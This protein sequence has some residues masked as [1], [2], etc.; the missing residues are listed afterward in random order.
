MSFVW[1]ESAVVR[2]LAS[3]SLV[4]ALLAS[5]ALADDEGPLVGDP[6]NGARLYQKATGD[7]SAKVDGAWLNRYGD[8][9]ALKALRSGQAGFPRIDGDFDLNRWDVLA[10]L[11]G[12]NA[13]L[14]RLVPDA[15]HVLLTSGE[16]DQHAEDRLKDRAGVKVGSGDKE[17][18]VFALFR[19]ESA[20]EG[21]LARVS[22]KDH[23]HRD[24]LKPDKKVGYV[25]FMPLKGLR[26]GDYEAAIALSPDIEIL[27]VDVRAPDGSAPDDLNQAAKRFVG[28]GG[29]ADYQA[30]KAA[31][32]GK[33]M[34]EI[35]KPLSDAFLLGA[36][37]VYM[38]EAKER[39]YF[40]FDE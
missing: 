4:L 28:R 24:Q 2:S 26:G 20:D 19:L 18:A 37:R 17:G 35:A 30:L 11:R 39:D 36:E 22:E 16:L 6:Y 33:A 38:Y 27:A 10:Y 40:A 5:P 23:K 34:R 25:V 3:C 7:K 14:Q 31:G 1:K 13:D 21:S 29:R 8:A 9:A 32:A 12:H 15:S